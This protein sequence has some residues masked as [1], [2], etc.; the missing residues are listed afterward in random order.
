MRALVIA[1]EPLNSAGPEAI[2]PHLSQFYKLLN[3]LF[4]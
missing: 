2:A 4:G 1:V 3:S